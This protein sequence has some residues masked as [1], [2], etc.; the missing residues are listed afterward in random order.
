VGLST[1]SNTMK[2]EDNFLLGECFS[3]RCRG[4]IDAIIVPAKIIVSKSS[5]K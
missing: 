4:H 1:Y 2:I 3:I 5:F